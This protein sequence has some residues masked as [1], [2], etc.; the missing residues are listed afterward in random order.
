[1]E[2]HEALGDVEGEHKLLERELEVALVGGW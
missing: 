1:V 2:V